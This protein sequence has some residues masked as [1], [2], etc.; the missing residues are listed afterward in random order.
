MTALRFK[1]M[2]GGNTTMRYLSDDYPYNCRPIDRQ[3]LRLM[4]MDE[5]IKSLG[6]RIRELRVQRGWSQEE[7]A[8][9]CGVH[10]TYIG[11]L[12]RG[13]KN[14]SF[15]SLARVAGALSIP[16]SEL[17][18]DLERAGMQAKEQAQ[19]PRRNSGDR[20]NKDTLLK[21]LAVL[22]RGVQSLKEVVLGR[23]QQSPKS[24][25]SRRSSRKP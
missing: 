8:D 24:H 18:T 13:E 23:V 9:V 5:L 22:E 19:P 6:R 20:L 1:L 15:S 11:H 25:H 10:R 21:K 17:F 7:F 3:S 16:I 12:E 2:D 4:A 14:V